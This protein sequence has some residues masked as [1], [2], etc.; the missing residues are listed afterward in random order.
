MNKFYFFFLAVIMSCTTSS[1]INIPYS[2][3]NNGNNFNSDI[4][5][6]IESRTNKNDYE[7]YFH[8]YE[9]LDKP[10]KVSIKV[11]SRSSKLS[12][13][14]GSIDFNL[15]VKKDNNGII[16]SFK[17]YSISD[18]ED[19]HVISILA[20]NEYIS[21]DEF[22]QRHCLA[23]IKNS[24]ERN[25]LNKEGNENYESI[26]G[27]WKIVEDDLLNGGM[28][29]FRED[30][31]YVYIPAKPSILGKSFMAKWELKNNILLLQNYVE[32]NNEIHWSNNEIL[33]VDDSELEFKKIMK[34]KLLED[35]IVKFKK[36]KFKI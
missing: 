6:W 12:S 35:R 29:I 14:N 26:L 21:R 11:C 22:I 2:V 25:V 34:S 20:K 23:S 8:S 30:M 17:E 27:V 4:T 16:L 24:F 3:K 1:E 10:I 15:F 7:Y 13:L 5:K 9:N 18:E 28:Y 33:K 31:T 32:V 19:G 36:I